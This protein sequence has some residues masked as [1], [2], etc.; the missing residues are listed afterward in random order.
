MSWNNPLKRSHAGVDAPAAAQ[1]PSLKAVSSN[2]AEFAA[3][4]DELRQRLAE[5][6]DGKLRAEQIDARSH[7]F[8]YGYI[9]SLSA[10]SFLALLEENYGTRIEDAE[11]LDQLSTLDAI[12][13]RIRSSR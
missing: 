9:D 5:F 4:V 7:L 11:L 1:A 3:L 8:D 6:S 13:V 12:A 10:V 2:D